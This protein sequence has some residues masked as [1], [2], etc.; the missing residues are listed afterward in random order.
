LFIFINRCLYLLIFVNIVLTFVNIWWSFGHSCWYLMIYVDCWWNLFIFDDIHWYWYVNAKRPASAKG[1]PKPPPPT[2]PLCQ[3]KPYK[4]YNFLD[5]CPRWPW[6]KVYQTE[7]NTERQHFKNHY[8]TQWI[9]PYV[10]GRRS[11]Q[12]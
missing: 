12:N 5:F 6:W 4:T 10:C 1:R 11:A 3:R 9:W 7:R 8:K 2:H